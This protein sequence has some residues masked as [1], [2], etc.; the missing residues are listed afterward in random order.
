MQD[1]KQ[2]LQ[3]NPE[4]TMEF[5]IPDNTIIRIPYPLKETLDEFMEKTQNFSKNN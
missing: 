5:D 3:A 1:N 4:Y 2:G